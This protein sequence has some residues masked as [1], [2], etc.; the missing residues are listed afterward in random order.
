MFRP[1]LSGSAQVLFHNRL[2]DQHNQ[3]GKIG[4]FD[5]E[6]Q[7]VQ[8][9]ISSLRKSGN[10]NYRIVLELDAGVGFADIVLHKRAP[11][12]SQALKLLARVPP[13]LAPILDFDIA[14]NIKTCKE[15]TDLLGLTGTSASRLVRQ[16][17]KLEI[18]EVGPSNARISSVKAPPFET[19]ISIEAKLSDWSRA[20]VQAYRNRQFADES[21]VVLDHR[22]YKPAA[23][24]IDRFQ[25]S[26][27]GLASVD[28]E[29]NLY[30]HH[31]APSSSIDKTK[32]WHAQA[33][34]ARR[35]YKST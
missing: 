9:L 16:L 12:T 25:R 3:I 6:E 15:L 32:R 8:T 20:L 10:R 18:L 5:T 27:V 4:F 21:W 34:L 30:I 23:S 35:V 33:A 11:R 14:K 17:Q 31:R 7:L 26:G 22:Y 19:I 24:Q 29:G 28:I 1:E 2:M 13:R